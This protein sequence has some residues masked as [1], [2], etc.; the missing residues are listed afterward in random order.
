MKIFK[1]LLVVAIALGMMACNNEQDV[2]EIS[3][4]KDAS[5]SI[6][7]VP[8]S[9]SPS[10]RAVGNLS[11][12]GI[13]G[14]GLEAESAIHQLEVWVFSGDV[15][16]GYGSAQGYEV[17]NV[18]AIAGES[19]VVVVA[20]AN[21][22]IKVSMADLLDEV[23]GLPTDIST[24]G[25]I[26]TAEPIDVTLNAGNNY[27]GYTEADVTAEVGEAKTTLSTTPLE[28]TRVNARV[29]IVSAELD[30]ENVPKTQKAVF[31][32]L[33]D[34]EVAMFNVPSKTKLFGN[35]L[36][37]DADFQFGA[38]WDSPDVA[39]V[40]ANVAESVSNPTLYDAVVVDANANALPIVPSKAP[41][42]Y[43]NENT[44]TEDA[45]KMFIVL[46]AKVYNDADVVTSLDGLYTDGEGYTYYPVWVNKD[47][48]SAPS[49]SIGNGNVYRNTQYNISLT[50]KGLGNPTIDDVDKA[51]LDVKV[52]VAPWNVVT[53]N[54]V[55]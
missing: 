7:V 5:I 2:P 28:I 39:Y 17:T 50:I 31:T 54:V 8:S 37:T 19:S 23:K 12:D 47:G 14:Q 41:F 11:G 32:H 20:N 26:M 40:G 53:Q 33:G 46:R 24:N 16:T 51:F 55:W 36:A 18:E 9:D 10:F 52:K 21:I 3:G 44:S 42:Y 48:I 45:Q 38:K 25:L 49:G 43:V 30:Y 15:L 22:G 13:I 27:Y 6:K 4:E 34:I 35:S 29:A 1:V